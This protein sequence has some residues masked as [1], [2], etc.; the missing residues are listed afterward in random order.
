MKSSEDEGCLPELFTEDRWKELAAHFRLSRRQVETARLLCRGFR[1]S[2]IAK[3]LRVSVSAVRMH[4]TLLFKR[5]RVCDRIGVP[6]RL[7]LAERA[8]RKG[9]MLRPLYE[10]PS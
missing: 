8:L 3:R 6:L 5:L 9:R 1:K 10:R 7:V 4:T 2:D